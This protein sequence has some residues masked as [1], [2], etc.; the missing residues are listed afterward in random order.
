MIN[1]RRLRCF[2]AAVNG[3]GFGKAA[4]RLNIARPAF[5]RHI[6]QLEDELGVELFEREGGRAKLTSIGRI[7]ARQIEEV[8][9]KLDIANADIGNFSRNRRSLVRIGLPEFAAPD[10][11]ILNAI[12]KLRLVHTG[13]EFNILPMTSIQQVRAI[14]TAEID[15]GFIYNWPGS[16][17]SLET[18]TFAIDPYV[19]AMSAKHPL[20]SSDSV[21]IADLRD[22]DFVSVSPELAPGSFNRLMDWCNKR[23]FTPKIKQFA[24][25]P[26]G[27]FLLVAAGIG[28]GFVVNRA[29]APETVVKKPIN[30]MQLSVSVDFIWRRSETRQAVLTAIRTL[31]E[32]LEHPPIM[33]EAFLSM[34][35][36]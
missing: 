12:N 35:E 13:I 36:Q 9:A 10:E 27:L 7:Y 15:I 33:K 14:E 18:H 24:P 16:S 25:T 21:N 5:S 8:L 19:L 2:M 32:V 1:L 4:D 31:T 20:A 29:C 3:E 22:E 11:A 26:N 23:Y 28:V 30:D 34:S 6:A 17:E